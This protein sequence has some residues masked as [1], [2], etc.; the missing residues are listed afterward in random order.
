MSL[1]VD[2]ALLQVIADDLPVA[3]WLGAVPGGQVV[4]V[5]RAFEAILGMG[6]PEEAAR[7]NYVMPYRVETRAGDPYPEEQMPYECVLR[8]RATVS[9]DD[10]V[11]HRRSG[12]RVYLRVSARPLFGPDGEITHVLEAFYDITREVLAE[13]ARA[14]G[15]ARLRNVQRMEALGNLAGGVAHDFNNMLTAI[16]IMTS[17]L[18]RSELDP[19]RLSMLGDIDQVVDSAAK[20]THSLLRFAKRGEAVRCD[21]SVADLVTSI[22]G[23]A[24]RTIDRNIEVVTET[25]GQGV[26]HG[27]SG[28]LEQLLMNLVVNARDAM[29]RGGRVRL[30]C[31]ESDDE[32]GSWVLLEVI[33]NGSGIER[34]MRE[35]IFEPYFT[36]KT[37][38]PLKGTG[39]GLATVYGTV[40][41]HGGSIDVLD[42]PGGG[43]TMRVRL[44]RAE[45]Q[46]L[47]PRPTNA[48]KRVALHKGTLLV[49]D[50]EL[51]VRR[52]AALALEAYGYRVLAAENGAEAI[53]L[54]RGH[55]GTIDAV[56]LDMVMPGMGGRQTYIALREIDPFVPVIL[57]SGLTVSDEANETLQLGASGFA[58]KPYDLGT[59]CDMIERARRA[60]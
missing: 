7:G 28:Q 60:S 32:E 9:L 40:Q 54:F 23:I 30:R 48:E 4:Y 39:L 22:A 58:P 44:P 33:D 41:A 26:V 51:P 52:A 36:T 24:R 34:A 43:T 1:G 35:R 17:H 29:P 18:E 49:V 47:A 55:P 16:K 59:L 20:L 3:I 37:T 50:D 46:G 21:L 11:V 45:S 8:A 56:V 38:G 42:S 57:T 13:Q 12:E 14:E 15:E 10:L 2:P 53:E 5:N 6:P 19:S 25:A 27:D 31:H